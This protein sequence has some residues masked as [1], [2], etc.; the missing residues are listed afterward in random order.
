MLGDHKKK[1]NR[2]KK[3]YNRYKKKYNSIPVACE[4]LKGRRESEHRQTA[5]SRRWRWRR[6]TLMGGLSG[7][8]SAMRRSNRRRVS[9]RVW[10]PYDESVD[11]RFNTKSTEHVYPL[12]HT[13]VFSFY[14]F[15]Q[16]F[17]CAS[18]TDEMQMHQCKH[19]VFSGFS[20]VMTGFLCF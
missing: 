9:T 20:P 3:K 17:I 4:G 11:A 12:V 14:T 6:S 19:C 2:Y 18:S 5:Q 8:P 10:D 13:C 1:L 7:S 16:M 15:T